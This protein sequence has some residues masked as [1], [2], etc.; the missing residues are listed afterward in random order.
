MSDELPKLVRD[1][2]PE[3]IEENNQKYIS[4]TVSDSEMEKWLR[5]KVLEEAREFKEDKSVEELA[6]L[7][8][9]L[10]EYMER[11]DIKSSDLKQ[12]EEQKSNERGGFKENI[13]LEEVERRQPP[14]ES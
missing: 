13:I 5:E 11:E 3:I 9:V 12:L 6:D 7:Y 2:I 8:A 4:R 14:K 10:Q 1:K